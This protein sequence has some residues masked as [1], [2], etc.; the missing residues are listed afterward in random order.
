MNNTATNIDSRVTIRFAKPVLTMEM[1]GAPTPDDMRG[2]LNVV[3]EGVRGWPYTITIVDMTHQ[4]EG[5]S[6]EAR[7]VVAQFRKDGPPPKG[8]AVFGASF[9]MRTMATL[10]LNIL[11]I[12]SRDDNPYRFF[13]TEAEAMAW[14]RER[15]TTV[16]ADLKAN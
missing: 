10:L 5:L 12:G 7:K 6:S 14:V 9:A 2:A 15:Q 1:R 13:A 11:S 3:Y 16:D 8:T 4:T